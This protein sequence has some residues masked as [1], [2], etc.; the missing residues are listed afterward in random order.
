MN[1][2]ICVIIIIL[3][4]ATIAVGG[5]IIAR[6]IDKNSEIEVETYVVGMEIVEKDCSA[7]YVECCGLR[8]SYI[9]NAIGSGE[10]FVME[11]SE[12]EY[13]HHTVGDIIHVEIKVLERNSGIHKEY[14][15]LHLE[16]IKE[17]DF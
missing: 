5:V 2:A 15:I 7:Y 6:L 8:H 10:A 9:I 16:N 13:A 11:V 12:S 4:I 3:T 17:N 1:K 14:K